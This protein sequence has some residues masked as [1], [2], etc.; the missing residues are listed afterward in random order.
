MSESR[1]KV[2]ARNQ[3]VASVRGEE[4]KKNL[5]KGWLESQMSPTRL[6]IAR[7]ERGLSQTELAVRAGVSLSTFGGVERGIRATSKKVVDILQR[8]LSK[9]TL[10][11]EISVGKY[12]ALR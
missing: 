8:T 9:K 4:W 7:V 3:K 6:K 11:K 12:L 10:F 2:I 1:E 5:K